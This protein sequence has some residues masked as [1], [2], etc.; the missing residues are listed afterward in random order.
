MNERGHFFG[1]IYVDL[2]PAGLDDFAHVLLTAATHLQGLYYV[3]L[4]EIQCVV[5]TV[6]PLQD[7]TQG[8]QVAAEFKLI[9]WYGIHGSLR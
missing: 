5:W 2:F 3:V 6:A 1:A 4:I 8:Y 9:H 7:R